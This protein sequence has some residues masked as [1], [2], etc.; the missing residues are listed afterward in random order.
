MLLPRRRG[1]G[2][3]R[4]S[5]TALLLSVV[6]VEQALIAYALATLFPR[7]F[8]PAILA[9]CALSLAGFAVHAANDHEAMAKGDLGRPRYEPDEAREANVTHGLLFFND[10]EGYELAHDPGVAASHG[11]QAVRMRGD[12][13]DRLLYDLLGHPQAHRYTATAASASVTGWVPPGGSSDN[14][15]FEAE[16]DWPPAD[17]DGAAASLVDEPIGCAS[18]AHAL[19]VLPPGSMGTAAEPL[20]GPHPRPA[21][22]VPGAPAASTAGGVA[23]AAGTAGA[24]GATGASGGSVTLALPLPRGATLP[25]RTS[26]AVIPRVIRRRAAGAA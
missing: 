3:I 26:W 9:T 14:W 25:E 5:R 21:A 8:A 1:C 15:R 17:H 11:V 20:A 22:Q 6:P 13:H 2:S 7:S 24:S 18:D 10:D 23:G 19:V 16:S 12:D 4:T